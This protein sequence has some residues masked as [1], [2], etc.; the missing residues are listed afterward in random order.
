MFKDIIMGKIWLPEDDLFLINNYNKYDK[1]YICSHLNRTWESIKSRASKIL[2]ISYNHRDWTDEEIE[3]LKRFYGNTKTKDVCMMLNRSYISVRHKCSRLG[4]E[5]DSDY[6]N[7]KYK[8]NDL[9]FNEFNEQSCYVAGFIAADGYVNKEENT[10]QIQLKKDDIKILNY[11]LLVTNS[12]SNIYTNEKTTRIRICGNIF[13]RHLIENFCVTNKKS[14]TLEYPNKIPQNMQRHFIRGY[15]DGDGWFCL[16]NNCYPVA[17]IVSSKFFIESAVETI[18][19]ETGINIKSIKTGKNNITTCANFG[20]TKAVEFGDWIYENA[21]FFL[22][23]KY[24][25]Y[26]YA[27]HNYKPKW[28][29]KNI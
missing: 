28:T 16:R 22:E 9:F 7:S 27:K 11:I 14:L 13:V 17:G 19:N 8:V 26:L 3:L 12:N 21:D 25:N 6:T 4:L 24:K 18:N 2:K 20:G 15:F 10:I 23:R 29:Y 5:K 1:D